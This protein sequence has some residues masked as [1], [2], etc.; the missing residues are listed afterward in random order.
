M[1]KKQ[2]VH[3]LSKEERERYEKQRAELKNFQ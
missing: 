1:A 3:R 2:K